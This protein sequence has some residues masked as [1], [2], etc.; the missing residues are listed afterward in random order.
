MKTKHIQISIL[1]PARKRVDY[2]TL[3]SDGVESK[4]LGMYNIVFD[5]TT[6]K[7]VGGSTDGAIGITYGAIENIDEALVTLRTKRLID[8]WLALGNLI[9]EKHFPKG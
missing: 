2:H 4:Q 9:L 7:W 6:S 3:D 1:E 8:L 5:E